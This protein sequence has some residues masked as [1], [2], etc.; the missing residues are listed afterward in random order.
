MRTI[1]PVALVLSLAVA[2]MMFQMSGFN[3]HLSQD[4]SVDQLSDEMDDRANDSAISQD[5]NFSGSARSRG[6]GLVGFVISGVGAVMNIA[7]MAIMLPSALMSLGFPWWFAHPVG[8]VIQIIV[9]IG[10]VQFAS[11]RVW[12]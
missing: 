4:N 11:G 5:G 8:R 9:S 12:Q 6:G 2:A 7:S 3:A 1:Y 10:V